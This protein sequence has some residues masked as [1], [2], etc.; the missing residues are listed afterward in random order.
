MRALLK[1]LVLLVVPSMLHAQA[2]PARPIEWT[3][4]QGEATEVRDRMAE[5]PVVADE[6]L[7]AP[8]LDQRHEGLILVDHWDIEMCPDLEYARSFL[9]G[10]RTSN[11]RAL[12]IDTST[13][14]CSRWAASSISSESISI[15]TGMDRK[16]DLAIGFGERIWAAP[17]T[18]SIR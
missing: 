11:Y 13:C 7:H 17:T 15:Q 8:A 12:F 14:N 10:S 4:M 5:I 18:R 9:G 2:M 1:T 6:P 3:A 16:S